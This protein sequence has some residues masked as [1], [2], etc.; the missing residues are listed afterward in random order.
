MHEVT[1]EPSPSGQPAAVTVLGL[2]PMGAALAAAFL[3]RGHP[4]T[5]W[6]RT[7]SKADPLVSQGAQRAATVAEAVGASPLTIVCVIDYDA[8]QAIS[9]AAGAALEGRTLV[10]LTA[11]SPE[12]ARGMAAWAAERGVAYL[13]GAIMTPTE[14]IG[15]PAAVVL[16]SGP[17]E[18]YEAHRATLASLGG[19]AAYLGADAGRA[20]AHDVALLDVFWT[21]MSGIV[22]GFALAHGEGITASDLAPYMRG[23]ADLLPAIID[24]FAEQVDAGE[25]PGEDSTIAS[26]AAGMHHI[27]VAASE[28]GMDTSVLDAARAIAERAIDAGH[29]DDGFS[30]LAAELAPVRGGS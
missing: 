30:R 9:E 28:R 6:N 7:A 23:I 19:T 25:Y 24:E 2:G 11:D 27:T 29:G 3:E 16:Y 15:G 8:V 20:A 21:A 1:N 5:V 4:T 17:T 10:S 14:T 26:A 18:V 13:D 22:H 12:R